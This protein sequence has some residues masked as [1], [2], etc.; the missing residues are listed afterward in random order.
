R[1]GFGRERRNWGGELSGNRLAALRVE[2]GGRH[3]DG[4]AAR[5][6]GALAEPEEAPSEGDA[7]RGHD[8]ERDQKAR[9][10]AT[11]KPPYLQH[12]KLVRE[13]ERI[14]E[15][16]DARAPTPHARPHLPQ[17]PAQLSRDDA[18]H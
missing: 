16:P 12:H 6:E 18:I 9:N 3:G 14:R 5:Q 8:K 15:Q 2:R 1:A 13:I 10:A 7:E 11:R 17:T 4:R